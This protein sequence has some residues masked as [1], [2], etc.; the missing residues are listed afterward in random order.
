MNPIIWEPYIRQICQSIGYSPL[1]PIKPG[2]AGTYPTFIIDNK[3]VVKIFGRLVEGLESFRVEK[4]INEILS[5]H[6]IIPHPTL[7]HS[8]ELSLEENNPWHYLIFEYVPGIP[9]GTIDDQIPQD[10]KINFAN[11]LGKKLRQLH[12]LPIPED[13]KVSLPKQQSLLDTDIQRCI[14]RQIQWGKLPNY[15]IDQIQSYFEKVPSLLS[16]NTEH[17]IHADLTGDHILGEYSNSTWKTYGVIDF[18]DAIIGSLE[19]EL[20]A[21][22]IDLF[23]CNKILL[24]EFL[25]SYGYDF[26]LMKNLP[27]TALMMMLLHRFS[28]FN[29]IKNR[30]LNRNNCPRLDDLADQIWDIDKPPIINAI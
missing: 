17:L 12:H 11:W 4:I 30:N 23:K 19:Y 6:N 16:P 21:I 25:S 7:I 8:G 24:R 18:G 27:R 5:P 28:V 29:F 14:Q 9:I 13:I 1:G 26:S 3:L 2:L 15:L 22:H 10:E 20:I